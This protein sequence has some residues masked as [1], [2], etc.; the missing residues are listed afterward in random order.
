MKRLGAIGITGVAALDAAV[1]LYGHILPSSERIGSSDPT[2]TDKFPVPGARSGK[3]TATPAF[4]NNAA[5]GRRSADGAYAALDG[6]VAPN[7]TNNGP[8]DYFAPTYRDGKCVEDEG[9]TL[10]AESTFGGRVRRM[11]GKPLQ[12]ALASQCRKAAL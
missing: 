1:P 8:D 11:E 7:N 5:A 10:A 4:S 12:R 2:A 6:V 3:T 9:N